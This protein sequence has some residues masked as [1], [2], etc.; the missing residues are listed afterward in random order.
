[1]RNCARNCA[2]TSIFITCY[3]QPELSDADYDALMRQLRDLEES[4]LPSF[5]SPDSPTQRV[6]GKAREGF[7]KVPH[8]SA[9]LSLD[10]A[11]NEAELR[12]FD[13]RGRELLAGAEYRYVAGF[14]MD[15][16][17]DGRALPRRAKAHPGRDARRRAVSAKRSRKT[18]VPIRSVL[19]H[20]PTKLDDLETRGEAG[21]HESQGLRAPQPGP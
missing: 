1:M 4:L 14:K 19:L 20:I 11:L 16:P 18:P 7:V 10:N 5:A 6:G 21:Q 3:D 13:G 12:A 17:L 8:S 9:M 15:G 2:G